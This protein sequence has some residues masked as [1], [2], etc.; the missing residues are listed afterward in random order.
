MVFDFFPADYDS[1]INLVMTMAKADF[2]ESDLVK[3]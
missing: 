1:I 3:L 2:E